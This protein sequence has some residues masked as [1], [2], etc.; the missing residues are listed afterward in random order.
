MKTYRIETDRLVIRCWQ[1][2]DAS[3]L[4]E[5]VDSSLEHL[6]PWLPWANHEPQT[7]DEKIELLRGFRARYDQDEDHVLGIFDRQE[8]RALGGSGLHTRSGPNEREIG[9]W[10]R[11]DRA[12]DGIVTEA[13]AAICRVAFDVECHARLEIRCE[14]TNLPSRRIPEKLG[15]HFDGTLPRRALA[16]LET[17]RD[18]CLYSLY[19]DDPRPLPDLAVA[20]FDAAGRPIEIDS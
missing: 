5:A 9:Y 12:N 3:M 17:L 14:P 10:V 8:S 11:S 1:P 19:P 13:V 2:R 15:F 4:K 18:T 6:R 16:G 7:I 20:C